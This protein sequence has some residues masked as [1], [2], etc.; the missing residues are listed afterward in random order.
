MEHKFPFGIFRPENT[1]LYL[2]RCSVAPGNFP[3]QRPCSLYHLLSN[4]IFRKRFVNDKQPLFQ[5][6]HF[7]SL[8]GCLFPFPTLPCLT[9]P[10]S[11]L[12]PL[13]YFVSIFIQVLRYLVKNGP[14]ACFSN[15]PVTFGA[16]KAV[17]VC[18]VCVQDQSFNNFENNT[19]KLSV[20]ETKLTGMWAWNCAAF[21]QVVILKF[22][23]GP[24]KFPGL[25]RN[26]PPVPNESLAKAM[27]Y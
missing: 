4:G 23:L 15:V 18:C 9:L 27:V 22:A 6:S 2:F 5:L 25:P 8:L 11:P 13:A 1:G 10:N 26:G 24:E 14:G 17:C 12:H 21:Q 3:L 7:N 16:R 20:D 19:M